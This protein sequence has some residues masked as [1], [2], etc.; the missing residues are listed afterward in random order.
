M[1]KSAI[2]QLL[3]DYL[4]FNTGINES[5]LLRHM[6][7]AQTRYE[8]GDHTLPLPWFLLNETYTA[9]TVVAQNTV[10]LPNSFLQFDEEWALTVVDSEG[11]VSELART[12]QRNVA[13]ETKLGRP[14]NYVL[15]S[16]N[17]YL[18]YT[19]DKVYTLKLPHYAKSIK[20]SVAVTSYWFEYFPRL[21]IAETLKS[22]A[23]AT[24][25]ESLLRLAV[26]MQL[27]EENSYLNKVET[28]R[29]NQR[30]IVMGSN[31]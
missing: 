29:N 30:E 2:I 24:R 12:F 8:G 21:I 27:P 19:P 20:L 17:I 7:I 31:I 1:E 15:G 14:C 18:Y 6:D 5:V 26:A 22:L 4:G 28:V 10:A 3:R 16:S 9:S 23:L 13:T 25:D 11:A